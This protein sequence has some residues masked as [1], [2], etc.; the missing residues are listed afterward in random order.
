MY[1]DILDLYGDGGNMEVLRYRCGMRNIECTVDKCSIGSEI[2]DFSSYDMIYLGGGA[3][4]EQK[5]ISDELISRKPEIEK[6]YKRGVFLLM[7]CGG[8]QLMGKYYRDSNGTKIPGLGL[9]DYYTIASTGKSARCIGNIIIDAKLNGKSTRVIGF[10][11]HGG[12]TKNVVSPFGRV[13]YGNG[14]N[15]NDKYEGYFEDNVIATYLHGPLLSKNPVVADYIISYC[16]SRKLGYKFTLEPLDDTIEQK[17]R[18]SL[19]DRLLP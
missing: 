3:D 2:K 4:V 15:T 13:L 12:M 17:C 14:N 1:P 19:F 11:N 5:I 8:Y 10:E 7:I 16:L 6:A 18:Q 9:F